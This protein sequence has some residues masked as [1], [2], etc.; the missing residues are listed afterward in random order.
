MNR[1]QLLAAIAL[2]A[3][4]GLAFL[5]WGSIVERVGFGSV[6]LVFAVGL[7]AGVSLKTLFGSSAASRPSPGRVKPS[8]SAPA[9]APA[10]KDRDRDRGRT[11]R[12]RQRSGRS[13]PVTT[14]G[15]VKWF[16]ETKGFGFITPDDGSKDC[17]VHRSAIKTGRSLPEGSRVEFRMVTD[18]KGREAAA[19]VV[20]I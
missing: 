18:D 4:V 9:P 1:K 20:G 11:G 17:F 7:V 16:D 8:S 2:A 19:D 13:K 6:G 12:R 14:T 3:A 5:T 15:A 10:P